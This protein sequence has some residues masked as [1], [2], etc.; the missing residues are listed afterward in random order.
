MTSEHDNFNIYLILKLKRI[1][2]FADFSIDDVSNGSTKFSFKVWNLKFSILNK[3]FY[4]GI[5]ISW[6]TV[7]FINTYG[8]FLTYKITEIKDNYI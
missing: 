6:K 7:L 3:Y 5:L 2:I 8:K 1:Y 4:S